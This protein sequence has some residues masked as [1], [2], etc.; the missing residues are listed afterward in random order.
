MKNLSNRIVTI[1][2]TPIF[3]GINCLSSIDRF[4]G[5]LNPCGIF[6]LVDENTRTHCLPLLLEHAPLLAHA[7]VM[8]V[9]GGEGVKT[10]ENAEKLWSILMAEG[11][12]RYSL[13]VNLGG[14]VISD[15][16]GFVAA[17]YQRGI[18]YINIPTS[19]MGMAD[20]A[21][22]GK[23]AVN[24]SGI[25]NQVGFFHA[26]KAVFIFLRFLDTLP[27]EHL[28]SGLAEIVKSTI[29]SN[30]V[31]WRRLQN[32]P[33]SRLLSQPP[34]SAFWQKLI[35]SAVTFKNKVVVKDYRETKFRKVL[36]FGHTIGHAL[37]GYAQRVGG[38]PLLHGD[39]VAAGMISAA[40]LSHLKTG[41][42][43]Q[44]MKSIS[45]YLR[46]GYG[47]IAVDS[48]SQAILLELMMHDKKMSGGRLQFT[49]MSKPGFPVVNVPCDEKEVLKSIEY[50]CCT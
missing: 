36:N 22:G 7:R 2:R 42:A 11:A 5:S 21:I 15:L 49:L 9:V 30:P 23:T 13:L 41:L 37:E 3:F 14:G 44:E 45:R 48:S 43:E 47:T 10:L 26:A 1:N 4:I 17:G 12:G 39:A 46:E 32:Y 35:L 29:I 28:R 20:A 6:I 16:G 18:N 33:V 38:M 25:K 8:E 31:L 40:Y 27:K 34:E 24:L 19:L 50:Q